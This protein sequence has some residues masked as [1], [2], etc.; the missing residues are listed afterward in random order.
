MVDLGFGEQNLPVMVFFRHLVLLLFA[1]VVL[2]RAFLR[3]EPNFYF[4][5]FRLLALAGR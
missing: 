4:C 3:F 2:F 1:G 5:A